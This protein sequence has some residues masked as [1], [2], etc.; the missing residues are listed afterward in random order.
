M[1]NNYTS[2][3]YNYPNKEI[4]LA[5]FYYRKRTFNTNAPT[6]NTPANR[7]QT[8][9]KVQKTV[10]VYSSLY[11]DNKGALSSY[12]NTYDSRYRVPWNQQS[13][14]LVPSV[15]K[16]T[17]PTGYFHSQISNRHRSV[18]SSKPGTQTPGGVG[19][20]IKHNSY[21]RYLNRLKSKAPLRRG[22]VPNSFYSYQ[23]PFN[24]ARPVYGGKL[25]KTNIVA[26]CDC[27]PVNSNNS[28]NPYYNYY[29]LS[30]S[31]PVLQITFEVGQNVMLFYKAYKTYIYGEITAVNWNGTYDGLFVINNMQTTIQNIYGNQLIPTYKKCAIDPC[32]TVDKSVVTASDIEAMLESA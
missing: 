18:T 32:V 17:V 15:Q 14:R 21:D 16:A 11:S 22:T 27:T 1:S 29:G 12:V 31:M 24:R 28:N 3:V 6:S 30:K 23:L 2:I 8:L 13:D 5:P 20:D 10:G 25:F 4:G 26:G 9:K 7:Y 19:C